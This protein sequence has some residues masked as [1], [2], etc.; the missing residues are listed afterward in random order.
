MRQQDIRAIA[1][2]LGLTPGRT[3]K[4]DLIRRIQMREGNFPCIATAKELYCDQST[5]I[6]RDDCFTTVKKKQ[7][8]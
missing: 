3:T 7:A 8:P 6:W 5:C 2:S 4:V 1:V